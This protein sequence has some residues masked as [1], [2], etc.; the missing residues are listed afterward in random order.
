MGKKLY[1]VT[2]HFNYANQ[3]DYKK[4]KNKQLDQGYFYEF[5][6]I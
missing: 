1:S 5:A 6:L 4:F 2:V 3:I